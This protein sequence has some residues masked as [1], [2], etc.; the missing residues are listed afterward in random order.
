MVFY[1]ILLFFIAVI[2]WVLY[3]ILTKRLF[4][5]SSLRLLWDRKMVTAMTSFSAWVV[6]DSLSQMLKGQGINIVLN[7]FFGP[8]VNSARGIAYQIMGAVNQ[9]ITS[10]QTSFRPQLTKSYAEEDYSFMM[11]LYYSSTKISYFLIF[12]ISLPI[13]LETEYILHLWLGSNVPDY[14]ASFTRIILITAFVSTF[15][16]PTSC[17]A[18]ATGKIKRMTIV[19]SS[20]MLSIV[21][22]AYLFLKL[23]G[24]PDVALWV[25]LFVS[26]IAQVVRILM[27]NRLVDIDLKGYWKTVVVPTLGCSF[28]IT[29]ISI[30]PRLLLNP[31]FIRLVISVILALGLSICVI[32]L[33]G[34]SVDE[35]RLAKSK[36]MS[37][38]GGKKS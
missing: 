38:L 30:L 35:K 7:L 37:L 8:V 34:L 14:T 6:V 13:L 4:P 36:I 26:V 29:V 12:V 9:F 24:N 23:G 21:P 5:E 20:I 16:N 27:L 19:V 11:K 28:I 25:S 17:I 31:S 10:F 33:F 2:D 15:A 32:W 3:V 18:Y 22:L 1:S